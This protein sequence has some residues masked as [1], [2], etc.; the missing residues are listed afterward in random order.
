[1]NQNIQQAVRCHRCN[2]FFAPGEVKV[3]ASQPYKLE[4][5]VCA[6]KPWV[7]AREEEAM[8]Q[9]LSMHKLIWYLNGGTEPEKP[10]V[11]P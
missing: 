1:M 4:I 5:L 3:C 8:K 6:Q 9:R 2:V 10:T 11:Q 7:D